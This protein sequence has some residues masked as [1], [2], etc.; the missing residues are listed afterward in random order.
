MSDSRRAGHSKLIVKEGKIVAER[1]VEKLGDLP[2]LLAF[3]REERCDAMTHQ[4]LWARGL[5][6][7]SDKAV[8]LLKRAGKW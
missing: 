4:E 1:D 7:Y 3:D 5:V 2:L 8:S 6:E